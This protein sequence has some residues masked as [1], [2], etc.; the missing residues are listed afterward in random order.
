VNRY[1]EA[2][3][4]RAELEGEIRSLRE[5]SFQQLGEDAA[6]LMQEASR[7]GEQLVERPA[8]SEQH[9]SEG[10]NQPSSCGRRPPARPKVLEQARQLADQIHTCRR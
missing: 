9:R 5:G 2:E 1:A 8:A 6:A 4:A 3:Q 7:S 10:T